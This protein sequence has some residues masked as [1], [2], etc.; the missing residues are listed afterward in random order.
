MSMA[1]TPKRL[2]TAAL[3]LAAGIALGWWGAAWRSQGAAA[4]AA[5]AAAAT[6]APGAMAS[7]PAAGR[8]VLY[9][10]DPMMPTQKFDQPGKS[11]FMDMQ[12]VPR[13]ADEAEA[14]AAADSGPALAVSTQARQALGLRLARVERGPV[15]ATVEAVGTVQLN[16]RDVSIVQARTAGFVERVYARA[17]GDV[18]AAGAPLVDLLNPEWLGAQQEYLAVKATG[19]AALAQ[20]A[21]QR[22]TLLGMSAATLAQVDRSGAPVAL[23]TVTAPAGG[24]IT[25]LAVRSGMSVAPGMTLARINGLGTVWLEA[26]LPEAQ[27]ATLR[28]GQAVSARFPALPGEVIAGRVAAILPEANRETRTLRL[29]IEL[30][31]PGLRLKAGL[32]AQVSLQGARHEALTLPAE[33]VIRTGR[34]ALVYLAEGEGRFRPVEVEIGEQVG[35]RIVIRSGLAEGQQVVSSGQFL[36]DSEASLQGVLARTAAPAAATASGT[37]LPAAPA[38]A[39][40]QPAASAPDPHAGHDMAA[41]RPQGTGASR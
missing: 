27:A 15:G 41:M 25:E 33:A 20:A 31:N 8:K 38:T 34:R 21:R 19:D 17:P 1:I 40:P 32:F 26:A 9:W 28:P 13:Y 24:V 12:L 4:P 6:A 7:A 22:L 37:A 14:G 11:P 29:R 5:P 10:Y 35:E 2:L 3:L 36:I 23:Q 39:M 16:E 30:P 18:V